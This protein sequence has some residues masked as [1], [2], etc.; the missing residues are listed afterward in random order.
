[1]I[2]ASAGQV[3]ALF[4]AESAIDAARGM[5]AAD[6]DADGDLDLAVASVGRHQTY[7]FYG[8]SQL[9]PRTTQPIAW[10]PNRA[11]AAWRKP[12]SRAHERRGR[13]PR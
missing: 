3:A 5:A 10:S 13:V 4:V 1:M 8:T 2:G 11:G 12:L 6:L 9:I 7:A